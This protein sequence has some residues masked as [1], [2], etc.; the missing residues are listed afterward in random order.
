MK[1]Y[2]NDK[3][4]VMTDTHFPYEHKGMWDFLEDLKKKYKPT[5]V[6][7]TGDIV[8]NYNGSRYAKDPDHPDSWLNEQVKVHECIKRLGKLFPDMEV[9]IGNHDVRFFNKALSIG[10]PLTVMK[11]FKGVIKAPKSWRFSEELTLTIDSTREQITF[12]H[13]RGANIFLAAQRL[14]R[15]LICGHQHSKGKVEAYNNG[16]RTYYGVNVPCLISNKGAPFN[17]AKFANINPIQGAL[18]ITAGV[19]NLVIM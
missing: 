7:H 12:V 13:T 4:L 11:G 3:I 18:T 6:V 10:I 14:G 2:D 5:R 17:Y 1:R 9:L 19:P 8:D 16:T 15:T